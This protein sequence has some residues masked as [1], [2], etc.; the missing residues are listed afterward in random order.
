M[1]RKPN[2]Y[3]SCPISVD[4]SILKD[5]ANLITLS[6]AN[7]IYWKRGEVYTHDNDIKGCDAF[8]LINEGNAFK[9]GIHSLPAGCFKELKL[10]L[11][12]KKE[13]YLSYE[14]ANGRY[15]YE[16]STS[17]S[18]LV[19][20]LPGTTG[21]F[22]TSMQ[23]KSNQPSTT[24]KLNDICTLTHVSPCIRIT[25]IGDGISTPH[26]TK[27]YDRRILLLHR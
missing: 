7:P 4:L 20:G 5:T 21:K 3:I 11:A 23:N 24:G 9:K 25:S 6:G 22:K 1:S 16:M 18:E 13:V 2:V 19:T 26:N 10:A 15:L 27:V 14:S 8:V 17:D 12:N